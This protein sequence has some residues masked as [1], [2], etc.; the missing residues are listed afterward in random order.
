[1]RNL[2]AST[3]LIGALAAAGCAQQ[4][5]EMVETPEA[6]GMSFFVTSASS[7]NGA[8]LG[9][10]SGADAMC[11]SMASAVGAGDREW[12]AYLSADSSDTGFA[13][14]ARDRIGTGPW[15]N[16]NGVM[17]A[18]SVNNLHNPSANNLTKET[19]LTETG[20]VLNG[21]GDEPNMHDV[22]T[23]SFADG[24]LY[25]E[26][27]VRSATCQNW[28]SSSDMTGVLARVGHHDRQ[29]GGPD[30]TSWNSSHNSRGCSL[31]ILRST[32]GDGRFY[33]F[34]AD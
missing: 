6:P 5:E 12:R 26:K 13:T 7:P 23:G 30:P 16:A 27:D 15:Y 3:A 33:C 19:V 24:T 22:L 31:E 32:G 17:V 25:I 20:A 11:Q 14:N 8:N 1:M 21:R 18:T 34:A 29:G 4:S 9:G 2:L 28:T 10:L